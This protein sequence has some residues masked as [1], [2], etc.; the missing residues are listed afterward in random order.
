MAERLPLPRSAEE[1]DHRQAL[2]LEYL[3]IVWNLLEGSVSIIAGLV[4][5]SV[6]LVA[7]GL[8]SSVVVFASAV[9]IW[10]LH[11]AAKER[12]RQA[13]RLIGGAYLV[14]ALYILID[15][16]RS[17]AAQ[18]HAAASPVGIVF[19]VATV[20]V[21]TV[22]A[23]GKRR[24]GRRLNNATVLADATFSFVDAGLSAT[25]LVGLLLNAVLSW[26]WADEV[27]AILI[28]LYAAREGWEGLHAT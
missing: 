8:D 1:R 21:M 2:L 12:E 28:S 9:V 19:M 24:V 5:G 18:H 3:T 14:V 22:L 20:A 23:L 6:A 27:L 13:L 26:W 16:V 4:A 25:V 7:F 10:A 15:G 17:L 11:G